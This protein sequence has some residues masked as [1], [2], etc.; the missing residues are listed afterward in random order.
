[1][2]LIS[3]HLF[4]VWEH[5]DLSLC[6]IL[7]L[8]VESE[9]L[10]DVDLLDLFGMTLVKVQSFEFVLT[11]RLPVI[12]LSHLVNDFIPDFSNVLFHQFGEG[13]QSILIGKP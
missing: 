12:V 13:G 9:G 5:Q 10:F 3:V 1:M 7:K 6:T 8:L 4:N 2:S 11:L